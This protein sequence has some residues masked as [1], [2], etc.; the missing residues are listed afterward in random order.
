MS[1]SLLS[2]AVLAHIFPARKRARDTSSFEPGSEL[3]HED[4]ETGGSTGSRED[5]GRAFDNDGIDHDQDDGDLDDYDDQ[6]DTESPPGEEERRGVPL[7]STWT[8]SS[9][10]SN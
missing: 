7:T 10:L 8:V 5:Q 4:P 9:S 1:P 6:G 3:E 2:A